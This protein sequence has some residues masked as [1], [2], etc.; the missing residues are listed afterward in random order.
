MVAAI[1]LSLWGA[2]RRPARTAALSLALG[3]TILVAW[4]A[5]YVADAVLGIWSPKH[6]LP[7]QLTDAVSLAAMLALWSR[8]PLIIELTYFWALT[9]SL[10]SVLTPDLAWS[11]PSVF[12]FTY[13][14]YHGAAIVAACLLVFGL[15]LHPRPGAAWR[16]FACSLLVTAI[17]GCGDLLTGG[18][19]MYLREKPQ[20]PSLLDL[21]GPWPWYI[22]S[23]AGLGLAMLLGLEALTRVL[24]ARID[25]DRARSPRPTPGKAAAAAPFRLIDRVLSGRR[26]PPRR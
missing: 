25:T 18:N 12:Y 26:A 1:A 13:F 3:L 10:Q 4:V 17:A 8:R 6:H 15:G 2:R 16:V 7:L 9:A 24:L 21:M 11:F 23:T 22:L 14:T 20:H 5:E 19:Y